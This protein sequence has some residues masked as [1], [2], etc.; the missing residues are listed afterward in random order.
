MNYHIG[1]A[2]G[3]CG[4]H[5]LPDFVAYIISQD[6]SVHL[7]NG[8]MLDYIKKT[9]SVTLPEL[10]LHDPS[11]TPWYKNG[12]MKIFH[13]Q[14]DRLKE[15]ER[16]LVSH[17]REDFL[18]QDFILRGNSIKPV[19]SESSLIMAREDQE[20]LPDQQFL[21]DITRI[22]SPGSPTRSSQRSEKRR[23]AQ[24]PVLSPG[25]PKIIKRA[26][27]HPAPE[28]SPHI[29]SVLFAAQ[30]PQ[31]K[32]TR[33]EAL[34]GWA[35]ACDNLV[36]ALT[37][38]NRQLQSS[39]ATLRLTNKS[40]NT[41]LQNGQREYMILD[42][43]LTTAKA[44]ITRNDTAVRKHQKHLIE[45]GHC[46]ESLCESKQ[47]NQMLITRLENAL[48]YARETDAKLLRSKSDLL[49][50][51]EGV[52]RQIKENVDLTEQLLSV[53]NST[54]IKLRDAHR[55]YA[56]QLQAEIDK[57]LAVEL[58]LQRSDRRLSVS[59]SD[60]Q[61]VS[62]EK[63]ITQINDLK[64]KAKQSRSIHLVFFLNSLNNATNKFLVGYNTR[65]T[66]RT[67]AAT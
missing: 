31:Q 45:L 12:I 23:E 27:H 32:V 17:Q 36:V 5:I 61:R 30:P 57:R 9:P 60:K 19:N 25:E 13:L 56:S 29:S 63:S 55:N 59:F 6:I 18:K 62:A 43:K 66:K 52:M 24:S 58:N 47:Q 11:N 67:S 33:E 51:E 8:E 64:L 15:K 21:G 42:E 4:R 3:E 1:N 39:N 50:S 7:K 37:V 38:E 16:T 34:M 40:L 46:K 41:N 53:T 44:T 54:T 28:N 65:S 49:A 10:M 26:K 48:E 14:L 35:H 2:G 20:L 22:L